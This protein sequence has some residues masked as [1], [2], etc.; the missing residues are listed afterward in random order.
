M[1]GQKARALAAITTANFL[2]MLAVNPVTV[3]LPTIANY[4][5]VDV[6]TAGWTVT[7]YL[8]ALTAF[9]LIAGRVGDLFGHRHVF[10]AG[11]VV[12]TVAG[13]ACAFAQNI[14]LLIA[15]RV[16]QGLGAAM[17]SGNS[18]AI[19]THTFTSRERAT[20]IGLAA[21][22]A[23]LGSIVGVVTSTFLTQYVHWQWLFFITLPVGVAGIFAAWR[24]HVSFRPPEKARVDVPGAALLAAALIAFS[25]ALGQVHGLD[26]G[27]G[28]PLYFG[29]LLAVSVFAAIL[30]AVVE[31][32]TAHPVVDLR[33][34]RNGPFL[35]GIIANETL[36]MTMM[37]SS[38]LLPFLMQSG[39]GFSIVETALALLAIWAGNIPTAPLSGMLFDRTHWRFISASALLLVAAALAAMAIFAAD[40]SLYGLI[41]ANFAIGVGF[42]FFQTPNNTIIMGSVPAELRGF[43]AGMVETSRQ[44]GHTLGSGISAAVLSLALVSFSHVAASTGGYVIGYQQ[45]TIVAA[46]M[47]CFGVVAALVQALGRASASHKGGPALAR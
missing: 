24:L 17:I 5:Q 38:F 10:L 43:A 23:S 7:S 31:R 9:L 15:L 3:V 30:F 28:K 4:Y 29:G 33:Y 8:L 1:D 20:P 39:R 40:I 34:L 21:S 47:A 14:G 25:L 12:F 44:L 26:S 11:A 18:L 2:V 45:A 32:R 46:A 41:A 35:C 6:T 16:I 36:H 27:S 19:I 42:G 22:A 37:A 13:T